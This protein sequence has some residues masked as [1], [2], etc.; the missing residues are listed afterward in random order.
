MS[1]ADVV[2]QVDP[3]DAAMRVSRFK[4]QSDSGPLVWGD[5]GSSGSMAVGPGPDFMDKPRMFAGRWDRWGKGPPAAYD[6][7]DGHVGPGEL[8]VPGRH[9]HQPVD[10]HQ[11]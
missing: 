4:A 9:E 6:S 11:G 1:A 10:H 2:E 5:D 3:R 7:S 8:D